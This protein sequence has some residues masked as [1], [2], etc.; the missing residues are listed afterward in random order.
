V[1]GPAAF[2]FQALVAL[3]RAT[4]PAE[5]LLWLRRPAAR[6][7]AHLALGEGELCVFRSRMRHGWRATS[8][9]RFALGI[10]FH[11]AE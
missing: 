4:T 10:V 1:Y 2:P 6:R 8:G 9:E 11:L 7:R 3:R 5:F